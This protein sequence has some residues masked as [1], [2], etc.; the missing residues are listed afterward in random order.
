MAVDKNY[1]LGSDLEE[2]NRLH[3][4]H[5]VWSREAFTL[6]D[7]MA[8]TLGKHI[9]DMGCGPGYTSFDLA[10]IV[11]S[12]GKVVGIDK[13]EGYIQY[14]KEQTLH[15]HLDQLS[16]IM[17]GIIDSNFDDNSFDAVYSRWV[18]SW[19]KDV[20]EV[21]AKVAKTIKPGGLFMFQEY[22]NWGTLAIY[23]QTKEVNTVIAACRES[24]VQMD[25]E[26]NIGPLLPELLAD[27][28]F[29]IIH[30]QILP[31]MGNSSSLVWQWPGTFLKIY[32]LKLVEYGLLTAKQREDFL[33]VWSEL[34]K[35]PNAFICGPLMMEVVGKKKS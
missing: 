19:I 3:F 9:L 13:T 12:E 20:E 14:A 18:L 33:P 8:L 17:T 32:S 1:I 7:K 35:N 16:F 22:L 25:S 2:L 29:E 24:W 4:Q 27:Y 31:K 34:E 30:Q 5:K 26:I 6:W 28:N 11:G 21:I 15:R 23:P 10:T